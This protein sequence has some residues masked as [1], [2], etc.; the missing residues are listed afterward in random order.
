VAT[1][2][3]LRPCVPDDFEDIYSTINDGARVYKGVIPADCWHEPYMSRGQ[4]VDE[5]E[6]KVL[7]WGIERDGHIIAVMGI[8]DKGDVALIRHAYVQ[9]RLRRQ[10][11]GSRLLKHLEAQSI[12]P[13]L[14]GTWSDASWA[15]SFYRKHGYSVQNKKNTAHLLNEYWSIPQRQVDTSVV[16]ANPRWFQS[17]ILEDDTPT[18]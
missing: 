13:I 17:A 10:G 8:Q 14:I 12:K 9:T 15:I 4:L 18:R 7:F 3:I 1:Q 6:K 16:L 2:D 11:Q 5:L